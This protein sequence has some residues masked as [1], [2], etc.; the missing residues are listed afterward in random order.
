MELFRSIFQEQQQQTTPKQK[1]S[2]PQNQ[3][4]KCEKNQESFN[5]LLQNYA[6]S[7]WCEIT[8][9]WATPILQCNLRHLTIAPHLQFLPHQQLIQLLQQQF[10]HHH[11]TL[12]KIIHSNMLTII[13]ITI[14]IS[15][16]DITSPQ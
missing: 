16:K 6:K 7:I 11:L 14:T 13:T 8:P 10:L 4:A 3:A 2:H 15:N 1:F 12:H 5:F 9:T